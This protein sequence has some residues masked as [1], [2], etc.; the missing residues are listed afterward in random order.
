MMDNQHEEVFNDFTLESSGTSGTSSPASHSEDGFELL[1]AAFLR[2]TSI[3]ASA[4]ATSN[5]S[6]AE[7]LPVDAY[8][9]SYDE[10]ELENVIGVDNRVRINPTTGYP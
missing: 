5:E 3:D 8:F 9:A 1:P 10:P 7:S 2:S 4:A 6:A